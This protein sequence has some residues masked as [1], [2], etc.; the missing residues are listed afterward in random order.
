MIVALLRSS[1]VRIVAVGMT[2]LALQNTIFADMRPAGVVLQVML[3]FA[4]AAG[5]AGGSERGAIAGFVLGLMFDLGNAAPLGSSSITMGLAGYV[6]GYV[7]LINIERQWWLAAIF[8][9]IGSAIGE[10]GVPVVRSFIGDTNVYSSRL[11]T[12]VP[13]VALAAAVASPLFVPVSRWC[14]RLGKVE[15]KAPPE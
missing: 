10:L 2:L 5:A 12:V 1:I 4:A 9:A 7:A 15:W 11:Y 13:L 14:L 6:A 3:A 8:V